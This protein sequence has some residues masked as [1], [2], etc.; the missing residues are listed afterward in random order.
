MLLVA[1]VAGVATVG[2]GTAAAATPGPAKPTVSTIPVGNQPDRVVVG[3]GA[4]WVGDVGDLARVDPGTDAVQRIPGAATP[5][6]VDAQAV[7]ARALFDF[8][9]VEQIDPSTDTVVATVPLAGLPAAISVTPAAVW[10]VDSAGVLT[11]ID[12]ATNTVAAT[13]PLG[14]LGFAVSATTH[15]V[16]V[17]GQALDGTSLLWRVNPATNKVVAMIA[18]PGP[19]SALASTD[20]QTW[21]ECGTAQRVDPTNNTLS[22]TTTSALNGLAVTTQAVYAL[23]GVGNLARIAT[24]TGQGQHVA[25]VPVL[26]EGLAV[27]VGSVWI[28]NP[29]LTGATVDHGTGTL[30]R[31]RG[32]PGLP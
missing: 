3:A 9:T 21:A 11:R 23:D 18:T 31:L 2:A 4:V 1:V 12:P 22:G 29:G 13:I 19:C 30:V 6:A 14:V 24:Q 27:G 20:D 32:L 15:A 7:W 25:D 28:T 5:L 17:S 10:V 26:S 16:W 8:D